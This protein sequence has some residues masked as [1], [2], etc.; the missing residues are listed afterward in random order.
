MG[1]SIK[2]SAS[3]AERL[4]MYTGHLS[5]FTRQGSNTKPRGGDAPWR[6]HLPPEAPFQSSPAHVCP[7]L[8]P[9]AGNTP[10]LPKAGK[11]GHGPACVGQDMQAWQ[12]P[13]PVCAR[14]KLQEP[15]KEENS[16]KFF[17]PSTFPSKIP[18]F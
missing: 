12:S 4:I 13:V 8:P 7:R 10:S 14:H 11:K 3:T 16:L 9:C 5:A 2:V 18:F 6:A 1:S 15:R 17:F